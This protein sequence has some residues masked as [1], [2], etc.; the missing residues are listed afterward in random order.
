MKNMKPPLLRHDSARR[1]FDQA[2]I[3]DHLALC[4]FARAVRCDDGATARDQCAIALERWVALG[5]P[6]AVAADGGRLFDPA[7]V[8]N[9]LKW[10]GACRDD[11]FWESRF[12]ANGR[13][14]VRSFH[15]RAEPRSDA[16]APARLAP[17]RFDVTVQREFDLAFAGARNPV[18]LR[19]PAPLQDDALADLTI[20]CRA[21]SDLDVKL[22]S[23]R[24]RVDACINGPRPSRVVL[25]L[26]SS[27]IARPTTDATR[28]EALSAPDRALYTRPFEG[29]VRVTPRIRALASELTRD[30]RDDQQALRAFWNFLIDGSALGVLD[31]EQLHG[32]EALEH[33]VDSG[34]FDC[35]TGSA[36]L[37]ALCRAH[38]IPARVV[39]GFLLYPDSPSYHWW[40]EA[41]LDD[42]AWMPLDAVCW[43]LSVAGRDAAW[44]DL[45]FGRLDYRMKCEQLPRVFN[46]SPGIVMP[47]A[48]RILARADGP[49]TEI[50]L[51]ACESATPVYLDRIEV[52]HRTEGSG[53][54][55]SPPEDADSRVNATPL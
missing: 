17:R 41:W 45:F 28:I 6:F 40:A 8:V 4:G 49:A 9:F 10:A 20:D 37:V 1:S 27:F 2:R 11:P 3:L 55:D 53:R 50:G 15:G 29:L 22:T 21:C 44:R 51:Y 52:R 16:P 30:A 36:L 24:G 18:V 31:Y 35:Q 13:A 23:G 47:Q 46:R 38:A 5:L 12:V 42:R 33:V 14:L 39:S 43:D 19:M 25:E 26:N 34:W 54:D 7:E 32:V 48:F